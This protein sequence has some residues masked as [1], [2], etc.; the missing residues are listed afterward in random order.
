MKTPVQTIP[1]WDLPVRLF[2]WTLVI[3]LAISWLTAE[4]GGDAMSYHMWS[5]YTILTLVLFRLAWGL[6]GS[7]HAR[8]KNFLRGPRT[9][10]AYALTFFK[11]RTPAYAGHNPLGGW[12]I[13][14]LLLLLLVQ[15]VTGLFANDD[16]AVEGPLYAWVSKDTS[17]F[18]TRVHHLNIDIVWILIGM[19]VAAA[20]YYLIVKRENLIVPLF[21]GRKRLSPEAQEQDTRFASLWAALLTLAAIAGGVYLLVG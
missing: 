1:V 4:E 13:I 18:L 10:F 15:A 11:G 12:M 17:D 19:H 3:L 8:F 2:H 16:I 9:T 20:F 21:T 7:Y 14:V 5:G 6:W